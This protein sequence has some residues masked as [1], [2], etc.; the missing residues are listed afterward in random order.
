MLFLDDD[1]PL[2]GLLSDDEDFDDIGKPQ[3]NASNV[4]TFKTAAKPSQQPQ[5]PPQN[6]EFSRRMLSDSRSCIY[7]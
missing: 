5:Q 7:C 4:K 3:D 1:D 6:G 2:A